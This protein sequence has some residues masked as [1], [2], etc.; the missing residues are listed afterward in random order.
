MHTI[1]R[2]TGWLVLAFAVS[3]QALA[4]AP[5]PA[6]APAA[7]E[8]SVKAQQQ[9]RVDQPGNNA[10]VWRDVKSGQ[11]N[12]TSIPGREVG[13]LVQ[14]QARFPGQEGMTTAGEAWRKFR[15]GPTTFVGGWRLLL[16]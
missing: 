2:M 4:Q 15:N 12:Y 16:G 9:R 14:Q 10:P 8:D 5:A 11:Q 3:F 7:A 1:T 6:Q 13:V